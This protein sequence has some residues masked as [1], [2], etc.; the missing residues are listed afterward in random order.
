[1]ATKPARHEVLKCVIESLKEFVSEDKKLVVTGETSP[2]RD[3]GLTS[4][5][6]VDYACSLSEKLNYYIPD[7]INPFVDDSIKRPRTVDGMVE[8]LCKLIS[9]EGEQ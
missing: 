7:N 5:D 2:I 8:L 1:M 3:F 6:G 9:I 4:E